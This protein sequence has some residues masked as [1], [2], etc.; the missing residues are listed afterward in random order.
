MT[1]ID[2]PV[3]LSEPP[4]QPPPRRPL[5]CGQI[6]LIATA[7]V[8]LLGV[9]TIAGL[10]WHYAQD[11]TELNQLQNYQPSLVTQV[12]STD[13]HLIGQFFFGILLFNITISPSGLPIVIVLLAIEIWVIIEERAK[14]M[15]LIK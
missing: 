1:M 2:R 8:G 9:L 14:Y 13:K 12:Y 4:R 6:A 15:S 5:R 3:Q 10:L 7:V 11:L